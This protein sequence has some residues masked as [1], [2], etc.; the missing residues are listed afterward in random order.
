MFKILEHRDNSSNTILVRPCLEIVL[1]SEHSLIEY[2][3]DYLR[4]Y[5][6]TSAFLEEPLNF[7]ITNSM[8]R[9]RKLTSSPDEQMECIFSDRNAF[10]SSFFTI[11]Q[12]SGIADNDYE[13]P[14]VAILSETEDIGQGKLK[15]HVLFRICLSIKKGESIPE[16]VA[17][18]LQHFPI[19]SGYCGF[20]YYYNTV[21]HTSDSII[22]AN[23]RHWLKRFPGL[24]HGDPLDFL[25]VG[26]E[27]LLQV[28]W[29]TV[30]GEKYTQ[31][32]EPLEDW[33][34]CLPAGADARIIPKNR[35]IIIQAGPTPKLGDRN[36]QEN[37]ELY[38]S[39]GKTLARFRLPDELI[40][41]IGVIGLDD[42]DLYEWLFKFI[43]KESI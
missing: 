35:S 9:A 22:E 21:N 30:L 23:N 2:G 14:S 33:V 13:L 26:T 43:G 5:K 36:R 40:G 42:D 19:S 39:I 11:E 38:K 7:Y 16:M 28:G 34:A 29:L 8:K 3:A 20:S 6:T 27:G 12:H 18:L 41:K 24:N 32:L 17:N 15:N 25:M 1:F 4:A 10:S 31:R 37:L